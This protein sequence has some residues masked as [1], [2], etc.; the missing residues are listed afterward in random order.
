MHKISL[1]IPI[2]N[3]EFNIKNLFDEILNTNVYEIVNNIIFVDDCSKD[4]SLKLLKNIQQNYKK[5]HIITHTSNYGQSEC[6]KSA[7]NYTSDTS[8]ITMDG[9]GQN[10]PKDIPKLLDKYLSNKDI[11][12][13]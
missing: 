4:Q 12:L 2:Y 5:V 6:L 1:V 3:E 13:V 8:I 9:D 10:N 11:Y 7:A